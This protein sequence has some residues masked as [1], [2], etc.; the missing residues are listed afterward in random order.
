MDM[1]RCPS[2]RVSAIAGRIVRTLYDHLGR[3]IYAEAQHWCP[4]NM[5]QLRD[6]ADSARQG[7]ELE[8]AIGEYIVPNLKR[9]RREATL[10]AD[11]ET[12]EDGVPTWSTPQGIPMIGAFGG[13]T[14]AQI[15]RASW[16]ER[17]CPYV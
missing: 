13:P 10:Y 12:F 15:G 16:R 2:K 14:T 5:Q 7:H 6:D 11:I 8:G 17:V 9:Y 1:A 4:M 3:L